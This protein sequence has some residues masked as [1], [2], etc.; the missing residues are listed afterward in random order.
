MKYF[1]PHIPPIWLTAPFMKEFCG[2]SI[3]NTNDVLDL[4]LTNSKIEYES[5]HNSYGYR[6]K[7]FEDSY[8]QYDQLFLAFGHST[9][10]GSGVGEEEV[11]VRVIE[12][13]L[14]NTRVLN[15][16]VPS[17]APDTVARMVSCT[18]PYFK[19]LCKELNVII[20][21]PDSSRRELI[22]DNLSKCIT[23]HHQPP[24]PEYFKLIDDTSNEHNLEKNKFLVD[25]VCNLTSPLLVVNARVV[26]VGPAAFLN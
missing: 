21:W 4:G 9:V 8:L 14:S 17:G 24:F 11:F 26:E 16:G 18:V 15:F 25:T 1:Y 2:K 23:S 19:P 3:F 20:L 7:D 5:K 22:L 10:A 12:N 13:S 6:E